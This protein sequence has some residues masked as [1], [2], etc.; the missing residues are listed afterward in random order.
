MQVFLKGVSCNF[1]KY[2]TRETTVNKGKQ[3]WYLSI[4]RNS[5]DSVKLMNSLN[6]FKYYCSVFKYLR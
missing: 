2:V 5:E 1:Q 3:W 4:L 6:Y